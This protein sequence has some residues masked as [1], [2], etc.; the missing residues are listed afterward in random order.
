MK[1]S[2]CALAL[3]FSSLCAADPE[4]PPPPAPAAGSTHQQ[5][6]D[7]LVTPENLTECISRMDGLIDAE[8]HLSTISQGLPQGLEDETKLG[9]HLSFRIAGNKQ[10]VIYY[11]VVS[12]NGQ[13]LTF[14]EGAELVALFCDRAG[15]PHPVAITEGEKP[16]FYAEWLIKHSDWKAMK[17]MMAKVRAENRSEKNPQKAFVLAINREIAAR[18]AAAPANP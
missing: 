1:P 18:Q 15:L 9:L 2:L 8:E 17:K 12:R 14:A 6:M 4:S 5:F 16:V 7:Q 3:L 10:A 13:E 11:L